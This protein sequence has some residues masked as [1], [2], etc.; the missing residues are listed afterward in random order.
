MD[1][2]TIKYAP[3]LLK[4]ST[5]PSTIPLKSILLFKTIIKAK[6]QNVIQVEKVTFFIDALKTFLN[7]EEPIEIEV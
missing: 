4:W 5:I 7:A 3:S 6:K 2:L 1:L